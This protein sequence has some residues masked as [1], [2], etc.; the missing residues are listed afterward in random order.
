VPF[1][2]V[3]IALGSNLDDPSTMVKQAVAVLQSSAAFQEIR[4]SKLRWT[5]P[6]GPAGQ[7]EYL[8]G[9]VAAQSDW[10]PECLLALL[11]SIEAKLG[12]TRHGQRWGA[13]RID[14]DLLMV[15]DLIRRTASL[16]LPHPEMTERSFVMEPLAE[17]APDTRH[18]T[19]G[20]TMA[21]HSEA[22]CG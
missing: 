6:V 11:H 10:E 14:L 8:N 7:G 3:F 18:P 17:L 16:T 22:L 5:A 13:R 12:R 1:R 15:G 4:V 20:R 9:V 21:A 19:D 2:P